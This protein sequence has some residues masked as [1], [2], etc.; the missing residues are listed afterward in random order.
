MGRAPLPGP[1]A[2]EPSRRFFLCIGGTSW[3]QV[4]INNL[5]TITNQP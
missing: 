5:E 1:V 4:T 3:P 2:I